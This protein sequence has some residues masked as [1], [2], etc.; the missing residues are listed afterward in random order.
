[1]TVLAFFAVWFLVS[2]PFGIA[3][4]RFCAAGDLTE[5]VIVPRGDDQ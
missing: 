2:I 1:M 5:R 4:G 3:L